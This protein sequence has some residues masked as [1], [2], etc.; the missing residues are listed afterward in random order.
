MTMT[1][2]Q[3]LFGVVLAFMLVAPT[4]LSA[5]WPQWRG[6]GSGVSTERVPTEDWQ[7]SDCTWRTPIAGKGCSSPAVVGDRVF[8][9]TAIPPGTLFVA[10]LVLLVSGLA[11]AAVAALSLAWRSWHLVF[12]ALPTLQKAVRLADLVAGILALAIYGYGL[13]WLFR[14]NEGIVSGSLKT[15]WQ[16]HLPV[17]L[18]CTVSVVWLTSPMA[19][20]RLYGSVLHLAAALGYA[21]LLLSMGPISLKF[22]LF[23]IWLVAVSTWWAGLFLL[24]PSNPRSDTARISEAWQA[25]LS[26]ALIVAAISQVLVFVYFPRNA[27]WTLSTICLDRNN[28]DVLWTAPCFREQNLRKHRINSFAT[29]TPA[30]SGDSVVAQFAPGLVC[31]DLDGHERWRKPI[32]NFSQLVYCGASISP[33]CFEDSVIYT[34]IPDGISP[35]SNHLL[36]KQSFLASLDLASGESRWQV[37]LPGGHDSYGTPLLTVVEGRTVLLIPTWEHVLACDP[38]TGRFLQDWHVPI[39]Q[40]IPSPV[41]DANHAYVLAGRDHGSKGGFAMNLDLNDDEQQSPVVWRLRRDSPDIPSP[42]LVDDLLYT[43]TSNGTAQCLLAET[44]E[45]VWRERLP[46]MYFA[47]LVAGDSRV[48]FTS[49]EGITTVIRHGREFEILATGD[50]GEEVCAS[51]ALSHGQIFIRGESHLFCIGP[52]RR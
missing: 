21:V 14:H 32:P 48:F 31:F 15:V 37:A 7:P 35:R 40:C 44:G 22:S 25:A 23:L 16:Y 52:H 2:Q 38:T 42:V 43:V 9:T 6:D 17:V 28:G 4:E 50:I 30:V 33:V 36:A 26:T 1:R 11:I 5:D 27:R 8:L 51:P 47:S 24:L 10:P 46:G 19:R 18:L 34:V 20:W 41:A 3:R 45:V 49:S 39:R 29:P 12:E 13:F